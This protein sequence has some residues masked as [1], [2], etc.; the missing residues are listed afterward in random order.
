MSS[1]PQYS[2]A[3][4]EY[5]SIGP[6]PGRV[7]PWAE[8]GRYF[9]QIHSGIISNLIEQIRSPLLKMGY[10]IGKEA[11]LQI[12]AGREPDIFIQRAMNA[13]ETVKSWDYELAAAEVLAEA[14]IL[15]EEEVDLQALHIKEIGT[16]RLVTIIEIISP[17]NK[18]K[19]NYMADYR[20]RRER[21]LLEKNVNVVEIDLTRS[22]KRLVLSDI[23]QHYAYHVAVFLPGTAPRFIGMDFEQALSRIAVPLREQVVPTEL[24]VAYSHAYQ[25]VA[26]GDQ[27]NSEDDY[28]ETKLP[29]PSLL[30]EKQR[31]EALERVKGWRAKLIELSKESSS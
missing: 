29:F 1:L 9:H 31:H 12:A 20:M 3:Y 8:K 5:M 16:S 17:S 7:D 19:S 18:E 6:F 13:S 4:L 23:S 10:R 14:G 21:L 26:I 22:V 11:S 24:Q 30:T 15:V 25:S 28:S 27:I 2:D